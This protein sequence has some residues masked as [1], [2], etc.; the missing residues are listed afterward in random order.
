MIRM[1]PVTATVYAPAVR[2]TRISLNYLW[3]N[4]VV[5]AASAALTFFSL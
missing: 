1:M 4:A 5:R 2:H 3:Y